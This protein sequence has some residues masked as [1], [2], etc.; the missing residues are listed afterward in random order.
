MSE[1]SITDLSAGAGRIGI[2]QLPGR[3]GAYGSDMATIR[4]WRP[5]LVLT[6]TEMHELERMGTTTLS[7]DLAESGC[8]WLHLPITDLG[9]PTGATLE[10]WPAASTQARDVLATGGRVLV[11]CYGG[12]G[13]SGMAIVRLLAEM[14]EAPEAA[15]AR[16][17]AVRACA[18]ETEQQMHWA[19]RAL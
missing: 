12:C 7:A 13:R 4:G 5:D 3:F 18:V 19:M 10:V 6:V 15:L 16:L 2:C 1:F 11:H 9:V 8:G 17:R 14:G